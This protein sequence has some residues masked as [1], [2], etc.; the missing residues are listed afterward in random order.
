MRGKHRTAQAIQSLRTLRQDIA[1]TRAFMGLL[2][3]IKHFLQTPF[4]TGE[5]EVTE[6]KKQ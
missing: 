3:T 5:N 1:T 6:S 2:H 4:H